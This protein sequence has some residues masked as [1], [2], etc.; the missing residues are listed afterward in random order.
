[1]LES[2]KGVGWTHVAFVHAGRDTSLYVDGVLVG[3][4]TPAN[5]RAVRAS[6]KAL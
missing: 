5:S 6:C 4:T 2:V 3:A 1:M